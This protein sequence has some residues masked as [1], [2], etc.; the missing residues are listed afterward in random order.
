M[1]YDHKILL[2]WLGSL[3]KVLHLLGQSLQE[4]TGD[5]SSCIHLQ[6]KL[7]ILYT[8]LQ[9]IVCRSK[10]HVTDDLDE[11]IDMQRCAT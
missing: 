11:V 2:A 7:K 5:D 10:S 9:S 1:C 6:C 4:A 3:F 8:H